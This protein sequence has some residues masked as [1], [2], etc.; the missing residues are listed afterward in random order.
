MKRMLTALLLIALFLPASAL[1]EPNASDLDLSGLSLNELI[2][3][4]ERVTKAMWE[5][6]EWQEVFVPIGVY[7]VGTDI[8]ADHWTITAAPG[9]EA[10]V[11]WGTKLNSTK[12]A[13]EDLLSF[14]TL[15]SVSAPGYDK[16]KHIE[17]VDREL[18]EG[19][20]LVISMG[21]VVFTPYSG[22]PS[23]GFK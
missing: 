9:T 3:L 16:S 12:T 8:P 5:T 22:K 17:S 7:E 4:Q 11:Y 23:L 10:W 6:D 2:A 1:A 13:I 18:G 19:E 20:Y 21:G 14:S 15:R